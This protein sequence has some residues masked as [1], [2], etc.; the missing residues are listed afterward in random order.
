M[1][2]VANQRRRERGQ[3]E[4][5]FGIGLG[6]GEI[7]LGNVGT[8]A[9]LGFNVIGPTVNLSARIEA[10][11]KPLGIPLLASSDFAAAC[12]EVLRHVGRFPLKGLAS[13]QDVFTIAELG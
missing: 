12:G 7:A 5:A 6:I 4:L 13:D 2:V 11:T 8:Q 3:R 10:L 1:A 9:R